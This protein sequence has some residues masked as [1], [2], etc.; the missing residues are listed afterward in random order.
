M[1]TEFQQISAKLRP[2]WFLRH[3]TTKAPRGWYVLEYGLSTTTAVRMVTG[4]FP[5]EDLAYVTSLYPEAFVEV[6]AMRER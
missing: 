1:S 6:A 3:D 4:A 2:G 5:P